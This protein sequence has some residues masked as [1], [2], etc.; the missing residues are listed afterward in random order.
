M[1]YWP[2]RKNQRLKNY[3]YSSAWYYFVTFCTKGRIDYF[4]EI[5]DGEMILN[6]YGDMVQQSFIR[7]QEIRKEIDIDEYII[8]PNHVHVIIIIQNPV[9][10][11][12]MRSKPGGNHDSGPHACGPY[13]NEIL[14]KTKNVLSNCIQWL[15]AHITKEIRQNYEDYK[16][17]WQKSFHDVIVRN[18]DQL[19]KSREYIRMNPSKWSE[20][21]NNSIN[22]QPWKK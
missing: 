12:G 13:E 3:D 7:T 17:A 2:E 5:Q 9:G 16:F 4:W 6:E 21:I 18:Q 11:A 20:D 8:M 19:D 10:N 15:K 22:I 1:Y 14:S